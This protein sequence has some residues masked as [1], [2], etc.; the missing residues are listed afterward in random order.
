MHLR[1]LDPPLVASDLKL[2]I[3]RHCARLS[4]PAL[5]QHSE[6]RRQ[7]PNQQGPPTR[8]PDTNTNSRIV[9]NDALLPRK[10]R[11]HHHT[12]TTPSRTTRHGARTSRRH[13][14]PDR[15]LRTTRMLLPTVAHAQ[16]IAGPAV[17]RALVRP[18]LADEEGERLAVL[19]QIG[20][21]AVGADTGV[22]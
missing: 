18:F 13:V 15:T 5:K 1:S 12:P 7:P 2:L 16:R 4:R 21:E 11:M 3:P 22:G 6:P 20:G 19:G 14:R 10:T 8:H 9:L 17:G